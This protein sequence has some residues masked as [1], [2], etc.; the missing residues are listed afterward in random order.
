MIDYDRGWYAVVDGG[1]QS[2]IIC[3]LV[4]LQNQGK[5]LVR[6]H[7]SHI[8]CNISTKWTYFFSKT[9]KKHPIIHFSPWGHP[10]AWLVWLRSNLV[11]MKI[12]LC[13]L[14]DSSEDHP[15][16]LLFQSLGSRN[17][18]MWANNLEHVWNAKS[19]SKLYKVLIGL[20]V[21]S[22]KNPLWKIK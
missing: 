21:Y 6:D 12:V 20:E 15:G 17:N 18:K 9:V 7:N 1:R 11:T 2:T 4:W 16:A 19:S 5:K 8:Y 3:K 13:L 22:A 14:H 10:F